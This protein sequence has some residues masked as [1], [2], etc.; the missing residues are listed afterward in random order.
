MPLTFSK[1]EYFLTT[2]PQL[3]AFGENFS[4]IM[5]KYARYI[6]TASQ[7]TLLPLPAN[8]LQLA[9]NLLSHSLRFAPQRGMP[10]IGLVKLYLHLVRYLALAAPP[11]VQQS[12]GGDSP[13]NMLSKKSSSET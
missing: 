9:L 12:P 10:C 3:F 4:Y 7:R 5:H 11:C 13:L 2:A 1:R 6:G 8:L